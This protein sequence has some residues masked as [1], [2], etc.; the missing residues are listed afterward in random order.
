MSALPTYQRT[1]AVTT[2]WPTS[3]SLLRRARDGGVVDV[4][5]AL[6]NRLRGEGGESVEAAGGTQR[7]AAI[8]S[9]EEGGNGGGERRGVDAGDEYSRAV[10]LHDV[11]QATRVEGDDGC[12]TELRFHG[13]EP[14]S[15][16]D[17]WNDQRR[18]AAI[19]VGEARLRKR[20]VPA[21]AIGDA[22]RA[23]EL[24]ERFAI[25]AVANDVEVNRTRD[26]RHGLK[27]HLDSLLLVEPTDEEQ[28]IRLT[29]AAGTEEICRDGHRRDDGLRRGHNLLR[30]RRQPSRDRCYGGGTV[31]HVAECRTRKSDGAR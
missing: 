23:G 7:R 8:R 22:E 11:R 30:L 24:L 4:G 29:G 14:Q 21:H 18:R 26:S 1:T 25:L 3:Q 27:Q 5:I 2:S 15:F 28:T 10:V 13:D 12:F 6:G 17:R 20:T 16:F 31:Q 9:V 19:E